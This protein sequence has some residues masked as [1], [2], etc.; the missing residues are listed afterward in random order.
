MVQGYLINTK[1]I[2][3]FI[4]VNPMFKTVPQL[5]SDLGPVLNTTLASERIDPAAGVISTLPD[6]LKFGA[7]MFRGKLL[8]RASQ[9]F[10]TGALVGMDQAAIDKKRT[11]ALQ[12]IRKSYGVTIFKEGDGPG[13]TTAVLAYLPATDRILAGFTN[14]FGY[15]D[16]VDF[17]LDKVMAE[18]A[19]NPVAPSPN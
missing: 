9:A 11:R 10:L 16:E 14:S 13:G 3:G 2:R 18:I 4:T 19:A 12:S 5:K 17:M 7:A 6:L 8:S 1:D 15:F